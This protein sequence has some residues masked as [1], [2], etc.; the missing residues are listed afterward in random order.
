MQFFASLMTRIVSAFANV[1]R[2]EMK[3]KWTCNRILFALFA[4]LGLVCVTRIH[5]RPKPPQEI[6]ARCAISVPA[7]WGEHVG[8]AAYGVAFK[9]RAGILRIDKFACGLDGT[10][11]IGLQIQRK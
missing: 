3:M 5:G 8:S 9:D 1:A 4:T 7:D 2:T 11:N 6:A 10:P